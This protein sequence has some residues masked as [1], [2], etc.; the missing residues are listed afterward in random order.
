MNFQETITKRHSENLRKHDKIVFTILLAH[1]PVTMF[2]IPIGYDTQAF[3]VVSS[4]LVGAVAAI[5]YFLTRGTRWFGVL[6][7]VLLMCFSAIMIQTQL[8]RLEMH[9]H[10]F[11]ALALL[12]IYRD[13]LAIVA[14]AGAIAVHHLVLTALQLNAVQLGDMPLM[15]YNYGCSWGIFLMHAAFVV[16]ESAILIYY[17]LL[18]KKEEVTGL[19]LIAAVTEVHRQ[20]NLAIRLPGDANNKVACA[21]NNLVEKFDGLISNLGSASQ[22]LEITARELNVNNQE[23]SQNIAIQHDQI[24]EAVT[25]MSE[26]TNTIH[27][28][29]QNSQQA[30]ASA[31]EAD[32]EA[33]RGAKLVNEAVAKTGELLNSMNTAAEAMNQLEQNVENIGSV[34][35]VIRGISE[36]TN[37]LALNAAIEAARAGEQGR[38]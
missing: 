8:G 27:A 1:L 29:A 3:A 33:H 28:V 5:A 32:T 10:I 6:S 18:M 13:W 19:Q 7:G 16:F 37:L 24:A 20:N 15:L 11:G 22:N 4:L 17:A 9:F 30:A 21:F 14:A 38:G 12:L 36:Q 26:M 31:S 23:T 34:V 35:D 2:L 25:A